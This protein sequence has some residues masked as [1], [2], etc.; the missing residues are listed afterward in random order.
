MGL[1][2][3]QN[4]QPSSRL[5]NHAR[6]ETW[7]FLCGR[8]PGRL[9]TPLLLARGGDRAFWS[10]YLWRD[11][12]TDPSRTTG[13]RPNPRRSGRSRPHP[14]GQRL[15]EQSESPRVLLDRGGQ[16]PLR[17]PCSY[18]DGHQSRAHRREDGW[19]VLAPALNVGD[20]NMVESPYQAC[21]GHAPEPAPVAYLSVTAARCRS[22]DSA[23]GIP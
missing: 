7:R 3:A 8:Y 6:V 10:L 16:G 19:T 11:R 22:S 2:R 15:R 4:R 23:T 20:W 12:G 5:R 14:T 13:L 1:G 18:R 9:P 21:L 17:A